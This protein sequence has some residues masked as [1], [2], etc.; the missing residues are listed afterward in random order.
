MRIWLLHYVWGHGSTPQATLRRAPGCY[1]VWGPWQ[2]T[3]GNPYMRIWLLHY[4]WGHG[5][6]PQVTPRLAPGC[7]I[8][9]KIKH[10][11][12]TLSSTSLLTWYPDEDGDDDDDDDG[13]IVHVQQETLNFFK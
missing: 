11:E 9:R 12:V 3:A 6:A 13:E 10:A 1:I 4:V 7:Y 8:Q 2:C 5:S